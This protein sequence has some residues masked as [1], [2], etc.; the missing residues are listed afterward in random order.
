[1]IQ[2]YCSTS[3]K[4]KPIQQAAAGI[5]INMKDEYDRL[6]T[7]EYGWYLGASTQTLA[8]IKCTYLALSSITKKL[9]TTKVEIHTTKQIIKI[10]NGEIETKYV[11]ESKKLKEVRDTYENLI[12]KSTDSEQLLLAKE[13]AKKALE[14]QE[15]YDSGTK[16]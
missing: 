12:I 5:I 2:L 3:S 7:R 11:E 16:Y 8:E 14:S 1:M 9:R 13:L 6:Y 15:N 4:D 10:L